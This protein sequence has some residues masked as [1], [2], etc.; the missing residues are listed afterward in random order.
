MFAK[1]LRFLVIALAL[2]ASV[3]LGVQAQ[4]N[5]KVPLTHESMWALKRVGAPADRSC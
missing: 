4:T 3:P 5:S 1:R 2:L